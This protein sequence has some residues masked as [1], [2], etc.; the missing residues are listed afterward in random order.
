MLRKVRFSLVKT[1]KFVH[2]FSILQKN[3]FI[4]IWSPF[5]PHN[6]VET[7]HERGATYPQFHHE[8]SNPSWIV[9]R[10]WLQLKPHFTYLWFPIIGLQCVWYGVDHVTFTLVTCV[11]RDHGLLTLL[12]LTLQLVVSKYGALGLARSTVL[13]RD[14]VLANFN[15]TENKFW[16]TVQKHQARSRWYY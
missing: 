12:V 6:Q 9:D 3:I 16:G 7:L 11:P 5:C 1:E 15:Q 8:N 10:Y 13:G 4:S 2:L 14:L